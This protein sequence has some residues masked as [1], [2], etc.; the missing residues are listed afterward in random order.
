[1]RSTSWKWWSSSSSEIRPM[2][3]PQSSAAS[4]L[5][6]LAASAMGSLN[7]CRKKK[8]WVALSKNKIWPWFDAW[9]EVF[10]FGT[11]Y[12]SS[13]CYT[14]YSDVVRGSYY[15]SMHPRVTCQPVL[16]I[17][18]SHAPV[19]ILSRIAPLLYEATI[20]SIDVVTILMN[21]ELEP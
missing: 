1:M 10:S 9:I 20:D 14:G 13:S 21:V 8:R 4:C 6:P 16:K 12:Q 7:V 17:S 2:P 11:D 5:V 19:L 3:A 18:G 15:P